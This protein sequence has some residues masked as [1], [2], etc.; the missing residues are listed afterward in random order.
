MLGIKYVL[1]ALFKKKRL[2]GNYEG[3]YLFLKLLYS[4][5]AFGYKKV[6]KHS[7]T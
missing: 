6:P 2:T 4:S 1:L 5:G 7:S 3:Y